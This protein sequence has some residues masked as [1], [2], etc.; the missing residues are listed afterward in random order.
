MTT[1][2]RSMNN[3]IPEDITNDKLHWLIENVEEMFAFQDDE[4][5]DSS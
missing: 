5:H 1:G 3:G 4:D 2:V